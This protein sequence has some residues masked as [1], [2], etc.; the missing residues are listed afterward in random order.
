MLAFLLYLFITGAMQV[1][2]LSLSVIN[3]AQ[4]LPNG[5]A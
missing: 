5:F 3:F 4:K 1:M 2:V